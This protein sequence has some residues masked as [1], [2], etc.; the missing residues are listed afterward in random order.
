MFDTKN[1]A[2]CWNILVTEKAKKCVSNVDS[3]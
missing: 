3:T 2:F 1:A